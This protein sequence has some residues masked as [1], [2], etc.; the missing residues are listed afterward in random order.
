MFFPQLK[1]CCC[2]C[3]LETG[4]LLISIFGIICY[5]LEFIA[6]VL[7]LP[8]SH[9][10][11]GMYVKKH[12][13]EGADYGFAALTGVL[14]AI[15][16]L[17]L[18][19]NIMLFFGAMMRKICLIRP[20]LVLSIILCIFFFILGSVLMIYNIYMLPSIQQLD[21]TLYMIVLYA[22]NMYLF[23]VVY[24]YHEK[25]KTQITIGYSLGIEDT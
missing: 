5:L 11:F 19:T 25:L 15:V 13:G 8:K 22:V 24:S 20:W 10:Y 16:V 21:K 6:L 3:N 23:L 18:V 12:Y 17:G 4:S 9:E 7:L 2:C 1:K 14:C